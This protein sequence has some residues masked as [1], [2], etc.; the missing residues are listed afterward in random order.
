MGEF[1]RHK[2]QKP[3]LHLSVVSS[4]EH[5]PCKP[6]A[7]P[8]REVGTLPVG[9]LGTASPWELLSC[10]RL[11]QKPSQQ[12][13][14]QDL[15]PVLTMLLPW[16][17]VFCYTF[18]LQPPCSMQP[19]LWRADMPTPGFCSTTSHGKNHCALCLL[20]FGVAV[21][22][23]AL[24]SPKRAIHTD[25]SAELFCF[26]SELSFSIIPLKLSEV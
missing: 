6:C 4:A 20:A 8:V 5:V 2:L 19:R 14:R 11:Q 22:S 7:D 12:V 3:A 15:C 25:F 17:R 26:S 16:S 10:P 18:R 24:L 21:W 9:A 1:K 23:R 13:P